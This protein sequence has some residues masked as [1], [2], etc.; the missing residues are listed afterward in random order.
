MTISTHVGNSINYG[1][2][3][4]FAHFD[5]SDSSKNVIDTTTP[6]V[7]SC[8]SGACAVSMLPTGD[9]SASRTI[10][11]DGKTVT[12]SPVNVAFAALGVTSGVLVSVI[13]VNNAPPALDASA[14]TASA[15]YPTPSP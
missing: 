12:T 7:P 5:A 13:A 6:I 8:P 10:R 3:T 2:I 9:G 15:E 1:P 11:I 14:A 4:L